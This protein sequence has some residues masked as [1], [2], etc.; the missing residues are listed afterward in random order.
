MNVRLLLRS[1]K[2]QEI[3]H[4][5][6]YIGVQ[7]EQ[8]E[9]APYGTRVISKKVR[10]KTLLLRGAVKFRLLAQ[11]ITA[12]PF[13]L[14]MLSARPPA[15]SGLQAVVVVPAFTSAGQVSQTDVA[16]YHQLRT[17]M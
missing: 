12:S 8:W 5:H 1:A 2:R 14:T 4:E 13:Q 15:L 10:G 6:P 17:G 16:V 11:A 9:T 3:A 7:P